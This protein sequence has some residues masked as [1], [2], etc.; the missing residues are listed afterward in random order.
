MLPLIFLIAWNVGQ[1]QWITLV[2]PKSC[3]HFDVGGEYKPSPRKLRKFCGEKE[4]MVFF[5]H[6]DW[7]HI[8]LIK[9]LSLN[10]KRLCIAKMPGGSGSETKARLLKGFYPCTRINDSPEIL[11]AHHGKT[12]NANSNIFLARGTILIPGDSPTS[13]E[14]IWLR[15]LRSPNRVRTLILGHHG[16][17]TSTSSELLEQL[18][19]LRV[20]IAS[21]RKRRYGHPHL[22]TLLRLQQHGIPIL[23]TEDWGSIILTIR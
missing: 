11:I 6:W 21:A 22:Q 17:R 15:K 10:V 1:G 14:K 20:A 13:Q 23:K 16:S 9:Y 7:D 19:E 12:A 18:H 8:G 3:S 4:N 5:S 2:E